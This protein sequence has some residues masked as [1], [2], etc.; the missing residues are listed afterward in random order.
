M[1]KWKCVSTK[2]P[3]DFTV[4][5]VYEENRDGLFTNNKGQIDHCNPEDF[6]NSTFEEVKKFNWNAFIDE[7]LA[8]HCRTEEEAID[9]CKQMDNRGLEWSRGGNRTDC[10]N[11]G[12]YKKDTCYTRS[13]YSEID[14]YKGISREIVEWRDFMKNEFTKADLKPCMVV[15]LRS[16]DICRIEQLRDKI[17][18]CNS[19]NENSWNALRY[20]ENLLYTGVSGSGWDIMEVYGFGD[21]GSVDYLFKIGGRELLYKRIEKS[22]AQIK[23][24]ELESKQR[25]IADEIA[26][27]R[28]GLF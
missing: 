16:G 1:R 20:D 23:L 15:V 7:K 14:F 9:F 11:W 26:K 8:V 5:K 18:I 21:V 2:Y 28:K 12:I 4:G 25:E 6:K 13:M 10:N 27:I 24:E 22:P 19:R 17:V 3:E